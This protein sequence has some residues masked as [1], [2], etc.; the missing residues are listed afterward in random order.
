MLSFLKKKQTIN[1][2]ISVEF[3]GEGVSFA[4]VKM[5]NKQL[6]LQSCNF[7]PSS[8]PFND[9]DKFSKF[10]KK[11]NFA[12]SPTTVVLP[13][14]A[15]QTILV[16]RPK[17]AEAEIAEA[18]QWKIKD[19]LNFDIEQAVIDYIDLPTDAYRGRGQKIYAVAAQKQTIDHIDNWCQQ[20]GLILTLI[21]IPELALLNIT[22]DLADAESGLA[23]LDIGVNRSQINLLSNG[24][25]Y[26]TRPLSFNKASSTDTATAASA[27]LEIQRSLD[28]Y[29]SQVGKP[30]CVRLMVM[31]MQDGQSALIN[32]LQTNLYMEINSLNLENLVAT[33]IKLPIELQQH[34]TIAIAA[35]MREQNYG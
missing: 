12:S 30:P 16:D 19:M 26:F 24:M 21:D 11:N 33:S 2:L 6:E 4:Q 28:Y 20:I 22:E 29:E 23:V 31:P 17:V 1:S 32:E 10:I 27:V 14:S 35:A 15:Y 7:I 9:I 13:E 25:L 18:L 3:T 8:D 5:A 34:A